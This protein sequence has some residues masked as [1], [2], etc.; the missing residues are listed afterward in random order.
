MDEMGVWRLFCATGLPQAY[1]ALR[2]LEEEREWMAQEPA[3]TAFWE[4]TDNEQ[5]V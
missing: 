5:I 3:M 4:K 1:L 2:G